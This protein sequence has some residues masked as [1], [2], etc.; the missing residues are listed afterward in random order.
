MEAWEILVLCLFVAPILT[1]LAIL[2]GMLIY[3][4]VTETN[5]YKLKN[6]PKID[7]TSFKTWYELNPSGWELYKKTV[8]KRAI[9]VELKFSFIDT[10]LYRLWHKRNTKNKSKEQTS[11][12]MMR[13]LESVKKDIEK[14]SME[15]K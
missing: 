11:K 7:F 5:M 15:N 10:I 8:Y 14:F 12:E 1:S 6:Y 2:V 3:E 9:C 13:V 4:L